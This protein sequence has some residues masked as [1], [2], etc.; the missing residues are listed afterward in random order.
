MSLPLRIYNFILNAWTYTLFS[1]YLVIY[2]TKGFCMRHEIYGS[3]NWYG[4]DVFIK[5]YGLGV[6]DLNS[7]YKGHTQKKTKYG[8]LE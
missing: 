7:L 3:H 8:V 5:V 1:I 6:W 2:E 4:H